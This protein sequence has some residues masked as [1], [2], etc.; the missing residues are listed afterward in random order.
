[1]QSILD[2]RFLTAIP[3]GVTFGLLVIYVFT[4]YCMY[5]AHDR[6]GAAL[7]SIE[8]AGLLSLSLLAGICFLSI[9]ILVTTSYFTPLWA[10]WGAGVFIVFRYLEELGHSRGEHLLGQLTEHHSKAPHPAADVVSAAHDDHDD[11]RHG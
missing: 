2:H 11:T 10:L 9:I 7:L 3:T 6:E 5:W 1:V 8:Q 4:V